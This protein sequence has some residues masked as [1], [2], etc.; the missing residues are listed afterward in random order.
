MS[1]VSNGSAA[2][3]A[4]P[5]ALRRA[6][7]KSLIQVAVGDG[8]TGEPAAVSPEAV[9][10]LATPDQV[11][12]AVALGIATR[13]EARHLFGLE[14]IG[15]VL[16]EHKP[17]IIDRLELEPTLSAKELFHEIVERGYQGGYER[18]KL[19]CRRLAREQQVDGPP[20]TD[21]AEPEFAPGKDRT[22]IG[23]LR[24]TQDVFLVDAPEDKLD[25]WREG[26]KHHEQLLAR[27]SKWPDVGSMAELE[28]QVMDVLNRR[29]ADAYAAATERQLASP[30]WDAS[31][32]AANVF[33]AWLAA[34]APD[35]DG[36]MWEYQAE[37]WLGRLRRR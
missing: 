8:P 20:Q 18:V 32:E 27:H 25:R 7:R 30:Q 13:E 26:F 11:L 19:F 17:Y 22:A 9:I 21:Q 3:G 34:E 2:A 1:A 16:E 15:G 24:H 36:S 10:P 5:V 6:V 12:Q 14:A 35:G 4:D 31:L 33:G 28:L 29:L 23:F 37:K